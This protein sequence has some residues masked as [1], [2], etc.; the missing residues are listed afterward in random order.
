MK[1]LQLS[2]I[3]GIRWYPCHTQPDW[4]YVRIVFV[5]VRQCS[6]NV[7]FYVLLSFAKSVHDGR[8]LVSSSETFEHPMTV[9]NK[10]DCSCQTVT[11]NAKPYLGITKALLN[12]SVTYHLWTSQRSCSKSNVSWLCKYSVSKCFENILALNKT[13]PQFY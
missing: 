7:L 1:R 3:A 8:Y 10:F 9:R 4:P 13:F 12:S 6:F 5:V 2:Q 11:Y